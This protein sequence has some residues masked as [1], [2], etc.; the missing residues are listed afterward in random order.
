MQAKLVNVTEDVVL[1]LVDQVIKDESVCTCEK[2]RMDVIAMTLNALPPRYVVTEMGDTIE[3][4]RSSVMQK[5]VDIYQAMLAAVRQVQK[6]PR[7]EPGE[8]FKD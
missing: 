2:C 1:S 5:R 6:L 8:Q 7:H 3:T 4:F